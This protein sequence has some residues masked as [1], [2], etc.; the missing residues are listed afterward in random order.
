VQ[1]PQ[2]AAVPETLPE[3]KVPVRDSAG[4]KVISL[5]DLKKK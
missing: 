1:V 5:A 4:A 3:P 2:E